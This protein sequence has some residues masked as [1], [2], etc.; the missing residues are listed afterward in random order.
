MALNKG[1]HTVEE[2]EGVRCTVV[3]SNTTKERAEFLKGIL[4]HN[5]YEVKIAATADKYKIGVTDL[6]FNPVIAIYQKKL[7]TVEGRVLSPAY[8]NQ[9]EQFENTSYWEYIYRLQ[10]IDDVSCILP[11][12]FRTV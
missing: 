9:T 8:W 5:K 6:I 2:I 1:K 10:G 7:H 4:E 3:E 11:G 12:T